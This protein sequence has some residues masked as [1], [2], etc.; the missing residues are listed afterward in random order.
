MRRGIAGGIGGE[1]TSPLADQRVAAGPGSERANE[2]SINDGTRVKLN[3]R[4]VRRHSSARPQRGW[5]LGIVCAPSSLSGK[6]LLRRQGCEPVQFGFENHSSQCA[7]E[8]LAHAVTRK[9]A[10]VGVVRFGCCAKGV[11]QAGPAPGS[12]GAPAPKLS[13]LETGVGPQGNKGIQAHTGSPPSNRASTRD[14]WPLSAG[15]GT[16][17]A[18]SALA[19]HR[20]GCSQTLGRRPEKACAPRAGRACSRLG[21]RSSTGPD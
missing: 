12:T 20:H 9:I 3:S 6:Q 19:G 1:A 13:Q 15:A 18:T 16:K 21:S 11:T 5:G 8:W 4:A 14:R 2:W 10:R 17:T 7:Q